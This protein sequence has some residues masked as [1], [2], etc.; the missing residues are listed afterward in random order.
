MPFP[1]NYVMTPQRLARL[2]RIYTKYA[3]FYQQTDD[4]V[5]VIVD[6]TRDALRFDVAVRRAQILPWF[7]PPGA[8]LPSAPGGRTETLKMIFDRRS[9]VFN[10]PGAEHLHAELQK[11]EECL[12]AITICPD[13][14]QAIVA[15]ELARRVRRFI[16]EG[17]P[18]ESDAHDYCLRLEAPRQ[19]FYA[20]TFSATAQT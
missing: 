15:H 6:D 14:T 18:A 11:F 16:Q 5:A 3:E 12:R 17:P 8:P 9:R 7:L 1:E 20:R 13:L 4:P 10:P 19:Y 2:T